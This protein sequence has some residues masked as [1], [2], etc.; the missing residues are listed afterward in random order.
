MT[1]C[2][3]VLPFCLLTSA[4]FCPERSQAADAAPEALLPAESVGYFRYDGLADHRKAYDDTILAETVREDFQPLIDEITKLILDAIG[5]QVL[6]DKLLDGA[7]PG[8]LIKLQKAVRLLPSVVKLLKEQ[9]FAVGVEVIDP[10]KQR[11]QVTFVFTGGGK[12]SSSAILGGF[13]LLAYLAEQPLTEAKVQ[14]RTVLQ[15]TAEKPVNVHCWKEGPHVVLTIGSEAPQRTIELAEGKRKNLAGAKLYRRVAGFRGYETIAHGFFNVAETLKIVEKAIPPAKGIV[16]M[17]GIDG[18]KDVSFHLGFEGR[19]QRS[20]VFIGMPG[21][22]KGLL[23]LFAPKTGFNLKKLPYLPPD[24]VA[25]TAS[26]VD[27]PLAYDEILKTVKLIAAFTNPTAQK[28]FESALAGFEKSIGISLKKD[29]IDSLGSTMVTYTSASEGAL[30]LGSVIAIEVKDAPRLKKSLDLL[31]RTLASTA[32]L[33][34]G[35]RQRKYRG[36]V[37][38]MVKIN[39]QGFPF[40][41]TYAIHEDWLVISFYPQPVQGFIFRSD[42]KASTWK[43]PALLN[44]AIRATMKPAGESS[45]KP[46]LLA[47]GAADPRPGM[48]QV[49]AL[50][51]LIVSSFSSFSGETSNFDVSLIPNS[52]AVTERL[53]ENWAAHLYRRAAFGAAARSLES[54]TP[55]WQ[56]LQQAIK[57]GKARSIDQLLAGGPGQKDFDSLTDDIGA[58]IARTSNA[59]NQ[60]TRA[61]SEKLQGWWL[62]RMLNTPH[63]L[64]ERCTLF[65][66][67]H[68]ATSVAKIVRHE[69]MFEQNRL[70]RKHALGKFGP[71]LHNIGR[72]PAMLVWLDSNRNIKGSPNENYGR[73]L[74]ELFSLGEG[75]YTE[76]DIKEAARA[77]TGWST[78]DGKFIFNKHLHDTGRKTVFGKSGNFNGDDVVDIVLKQPA[79]ARFLVGKLFREFI[80]E[81][82]TPPARLIEPLAVQLRKSNYDI[83]GCIATMLRSNLFFSDHAYR[84]RIKSPVEYV[85]GTLAVCDGR[86]SLPQLAKSMDGMGQTLFAPPNVKGWDG[87][88]TWLNSATLLARCNL[89]VRFAGSRRQPSFVKIE[90]QTLVKKFAKSDSAD[91]GVD[92]LLALLLQNDVAAPVRDRLIQ[93]A[94]QNT[95]SRKPGRTHWPEVAHAILTIPEYQLA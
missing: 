14:G 36:T 57:L 62:Y 61:Q 9:G 58:S 15:F 52:Q 6:G 33:D 59:A 44:N 41:P 48:K 42:G 32:G 7:R 92:F 77:F 79:A 69:L 8:E 63:P 68:F 75:N 4:A 60:F 39:Q 55:A 46:R 43:A 22:R 53:T 81:A 67:N 16:R 84:Q 87:G 49:L 18:L 50:A 93:H 95:Q 24:S 89:A 12:S 83:A 90:P 27:F 73:E 11:F 64:K 31:S 3:W 51:P 86:G 19:M 70:L 54:D 78:S 80:S 71:L 65:W 74:L 5:P 72:D 21:E 40:V 13:R 45:G 10:M 88:K 35:I 37:M 34:I 1:R 30:N 20:T 29:L 66:H 17:L 76:T 23:K 85:V 91:D 26:G 82:E 28:D 94:R 56:R 47:A 38:H 2:L 25:V